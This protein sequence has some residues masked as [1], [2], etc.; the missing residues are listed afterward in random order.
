[1]DTIEKPNNEI[2]LDEYKCENCN[3]KFTTKWSLVR[4]QKTVCILQKQ[5]KNKSKDKLID[6][7]KSMSDEIQLLKNIN[8][9]IFNTYEKKDKSEDVNVYIYQI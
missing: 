1:M 7:I 9:I 4:H 3:N 8:N 6:I 5:T 2:I